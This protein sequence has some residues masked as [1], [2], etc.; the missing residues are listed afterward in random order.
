MIDYL[1]KTLK[2]FRLGGMAERLTIRCQ[3]A[4]ANDLDYEVFLKQLIDDELGKRKD[5]LINRRVKAAHFPKTMTLEK[6]DFSFNPSISKK[7]VMSLM[8]TAF[9]TEQRN[10]LFVGPPGVGKTHI[11]LAIGY[12]AI[13]NGFSVSYRSSF[14]LVTDM[15]LAHREG[16]R[17]ELVAKLVG[18]NL[19]IIDEFGMKTMPQNA[20]DD[21]L[22]IIHRRYQEASTIIV[23]NRP[24][25]DWA[26]I[27]GD[28]P[29]TSAILDRFL[30]N[31]EF[32]QIK[33]KS[34]RLSKTNETVE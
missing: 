21:L 13:C 4:R 26:A 14:D 1:Q 19:L 22:E 23:T 8:S 27:L 9:V 15:T 25:G 7:I 10:V 20:A 3:E 24:V 12:A 11:A 2:S 18:C 5:N 34:Y 32:V 28:V 17:K 30:D 16:K 29:A 33:G 31:A 6:F